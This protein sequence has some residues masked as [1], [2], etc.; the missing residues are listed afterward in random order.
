[1]IVDG[2]IHGGRSMGM[3]PALMEE[4]SYDE[5]GNVQGGSFIDDLLPTSME[6]PKWETGKTV[7]PRLTIHSAPRAWGSRRPS[8]RR[9]RWCLSLWGGL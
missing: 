9:R 1:M 7:T 2:Q 3:A 6:T 4:I 8:A 5:N